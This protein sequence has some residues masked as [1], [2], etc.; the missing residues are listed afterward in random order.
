MSS[1][2]VLFPASGQKLSPP[3]AADQEENRQK[4][5]SFTLPVPLDEKGGILL[6]RSGII[7]DFRV[8]SQDS[9]WQP[10]YF[11]SRARLCARSSTRIACYE[12][13]S[14]FSTEWSSSNSAGRAGPL[15]PARP[16]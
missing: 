1:R 16:G 15:R 6:A 14:T 3:E 12:R 10:H 7:I 5:G 13:E 8:L 2:G 4:T 11:V 9:G